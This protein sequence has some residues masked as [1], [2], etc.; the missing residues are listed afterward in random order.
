MH[1]TTIDDH[2]QT[3]TGDDDW[4]FADVTETEDDVVN[5]VESVENFWKDE[6]KSGEDYDLHRSKRDRFVLPS[7]SRFHLPS[8]SPS[9]GRLDVFEIP[10]QLHPAVSLGVRRVSSCYLSLASQQESMTDLW[11]QLS[12]NNN[13]SNSNS[14]SS[15]SS[16]TNGLETRSKSAIPPPEMD[17]P[18]DDW[19]RN[20]TGDV[21]YHDILMNVFHFLD[22]QSLRSFSETARRPNFEVFYYLQLQLQQSLLVAPDSDESSNYDGQ[23]EVD[24]EDCHYHAKINS[25]R[26]PIAGSMYISRLARLDAEKAQCVV[27]EFLDSNSTLRTMPLSH[28]LAYARRYLLH[29]GFSRMFPNSTADNDSHLSYNNNYNSLALASR[30][31]LFV[32]V[33][34]AASLMSTM[35]GGDTTAITNS[36]ESFGTELPNVLFRVGFVG[37]LMGAARQM[38]DTEQR[39]AIIETA[40]QMTRSMKELPSSL[41]RAKPKKLH[42]IEES[43]GNSGRSI[44]PPQFRLPSIFEMREQLQVMLSK[45]AANEQERSGM[46]SNPYDHLEADLDR[47]KDDEKSESV[48]TNYKEDDKKTRIK[49]SRKMPSG[50]VGAYARAIRTSSHLVKK[51]VKEARKSNFEAK[52]PEERQQ[53]SLEFL[54]ACSSNVTLLRVKEMVQSI[55]VDGFYVG[56]D[57]S[58][59]CALHTAAFHGADQVVD[60]LCSGISENESHADG[61]LC[62]INMTD[63]NGWT[64]LHFAAGANAASV[65]QVLASH[66]AKLQVE[67]QNGY[68]PLQWAIRL[69]NNDVAQLLTELVSNADKTQTTWMTRKPLTSLANRFFSL[70]PTQ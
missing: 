25:Q 27:N 2:N 19:M 44:A 68:S 43:N 59:T 47:Q 9:N 7:S 20:N 50:C 56:N 10:Q 62:D 48:D 60:Y 57:G 66:G 36:L 46:L 24:K 49:M 22:D 31:A 38:S 41:M 34:G 64:A 30:A 35:S 63:N 37:S 52:S 14:N 8:S 32:T 55:D 6:Q 69:S 40:E 67:A 45:L 3:G 42:N 15:S 70:M 61:G 51:L 4:L 21:F 5:T 53:L 18:T 13:N 58:E 39:A 54:N 1:E 17:S 33:V 29:H 23:S 28:S 11:S 26:S 12:D 16:Q 65:V